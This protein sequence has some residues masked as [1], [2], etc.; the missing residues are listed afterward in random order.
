M[1]E[2]LDRRLRG[3]VAIVGVGNPMWGD[4]GAGPALI[5]RL[6]GKVPALL[7]DGGEAPESYWGTIAA[8]RPEAVLIVDGV[9][10]GGEPGSVAVLE[11][12]EAKGPALSTHR[13]SLNLLL[14]LL[15]RQTGADA[16]ALGIQPKVLVF[17]EGMSAEVQKTVEL[18]ADLLG[19]I[20]GGSSRC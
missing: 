15:R 9:D 3:K 11:E 20:L 13:I 16:F 14:N 6:E 17:Q 4:D 1:R 18:L 10:W 2:V 7:V 12:V 5:R 19:D 8:Y